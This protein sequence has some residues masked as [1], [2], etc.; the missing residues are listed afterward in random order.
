MI[1][2]PNAKIN[3]G[4]NIVN[5]RKDGFHNIESWVFAIDLC[6]ILEIIKSDSATSFKSTGIAIPGN[7]EENLCLK[8]W[9]IL[10]NEFSIPP[11][12]I[13][14]HKQIPIGAGI[15]GGSSDGAFTIKALNNLFSLNLSPEK[16]KQF[17]AMLGSDCPFFIDNRPAHVTG[18]GE[19]L[20]LLK[21]DMSNYFI[22]LV[23]P[24]IHIGTAE[25][26]A[27]VQPKKPSQS[28]SD[29]IRN[30]IK[31][32][33]KKINNDFE[34]GIFKTHPVIEEIKH[35]LLHAGAHYASMSGSGSSV[36]GIFESEPS[37]S[38]RTGF[39]SWF[40]WKGKFII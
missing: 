11:V 19:N 6:D 31:D 36:F 1:V 34:P 16:M 33:Q 21:K 29:L 28:V 18:R 10:S 14:L 35:L 5:K 27:G 25:A 17:S 37:E 22:L 3:I 8:G 20:S 32:W 13:H 39:N 9:E 7:P 38:I 12:K 26:Y 4:L 24:G 40:T 30:P 2:Y 23:N 15:G